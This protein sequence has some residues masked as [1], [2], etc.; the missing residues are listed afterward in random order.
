MV[1][2]PELDFTA[3]VYTNAW[4]LDHGMT[5]IS[6]QLYFILDEACYRAKVII[7]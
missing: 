2:D 7:Q 6:D 1:T 4:D 5:S 3:V